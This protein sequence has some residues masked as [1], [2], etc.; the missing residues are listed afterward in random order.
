M[1]IKGQSPKEVVHTEMH[2]FKHGGLH[3]G[4]KKGPVVK[5]RKQAIAIALSESGQSK[6]EYDRS[7]HHKGNPGFDRSEK[8]KSPAAG[9]RHDSSGSHE[10]RPKV[11]FSPGGNALCCPPMPSSAHIF[12]G[13]NRQGVLRVSGK[14]G[15]HQLGK[16][17]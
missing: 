14:S 15:A 1:P 11:S 9:A 6:G 4:S 12:S 17:K 10:S 8:V 13:T 7:S 16:R 5:N 3:S 2:K